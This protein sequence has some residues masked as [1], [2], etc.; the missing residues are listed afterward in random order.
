[1]NNLSRN[2][3]NLG[4]NSNFRYKVT[5]D[6]TVFASYNGTTRQPTLDQIQPIRELNNPLY[7]VVGNPLLKP[8]FNNSLRASL[9]QYSAKAERYLSLGAYYNFVQ[10]EIVSTETI[11]ENN[12]RIV[13]YINI[14]GNKNYGANLM[15]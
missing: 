3:I 4:P 10:N 14:D 5:R 7:Q 13:S 8:S 15:V 1:K 9:S 2:Y 11:D 12:K 6:L